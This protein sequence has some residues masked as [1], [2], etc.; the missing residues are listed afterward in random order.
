[1]ENEEK[2][3]ETIIKFVRLIRENMKPP[4]DHNKIG[5][6]RGQLGLLQYLLD[7]ENKDVT[8]SEL[9]KDL[10]VGSG[11]IANALKCLEERGEIIREK[12]ISDKRKANVKLTEKGKNRALEM[13]DV[14]EKSIKYVI[15]K[16]GL[17]NFVNFVDTLEVVFHYIREYEEVNY[18]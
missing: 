17:D 8:P 7:H 11:R 5:A 2:I 9:S 1:M 14:H 18:D 16:I 15:G 3:R 10:N 6:A 13:R 4:A 12:N